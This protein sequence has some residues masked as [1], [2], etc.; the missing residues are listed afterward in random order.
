[1][2]GR[3][4]FQRVGAAM[5]KALSSKVRHLVLVMEVRRFASEECRWRVGVWQWRSVRYEG[6]RFFRAFTVMRRTL[7]SMRCFM[8]SQ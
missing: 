8:G 5:E 7:K 4:E 1:M 3:R 2:D 6:A